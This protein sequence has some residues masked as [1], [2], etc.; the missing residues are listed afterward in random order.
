MSYKF[1]LFAEIWIILQKVLYLI[2][3]KMFVVLFVFLETV[4]SFDQHHF[5]TLDLDGQVGW[6]S[7]NYV[8]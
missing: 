3:I 8:N 1:S 2:D 4:M 7:E 6:Y 5:H